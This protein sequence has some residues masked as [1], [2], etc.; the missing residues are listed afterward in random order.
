MV[1]FLYEFSFLPVSGEIR[2]RCPCSRC[3]I[4]IKLVYL[5]HQAAVSGD[6]LESLEVQLGVT[7]ATVHES[8]PQF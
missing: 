3:L 8:V 6:N 5:R 4:E 1:F 7:Q 2:S